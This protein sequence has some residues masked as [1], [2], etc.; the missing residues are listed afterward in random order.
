MSF[1]LPFVLM[2]NEILRAMG[3]SKFTNSLSPLIMSGNLVAL[4]FGAAS[5]LFLFCSQRIKRC[6]I[7]MSIFDFNGEK[8]L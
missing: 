3:Y 8:S 4:I 5:L 7:G 1:R 6:S 2:T